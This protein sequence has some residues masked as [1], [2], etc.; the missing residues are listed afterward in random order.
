MLVTF[1][2][3]EDEPA[4][5]VKEAEVDVA[6]TMTDDGTEITLL[7]LESATN[8][9]PAGAAALRA[10]VQVLTPPVFVVLGLQFNDDTFTEGGG[11]EALT[12]TVADL[13]A[14]FKDPVIVLL[15]A[16]DTVPPVAV[17]VPLTP[18][19]ATDMLPGTV[20]AALLL[21]SAIVIGPEVAE[22]KL[23][24]QLEVPPEEIVVGLHVNPEIAGPT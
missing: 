24:V 7:L 19:T 1:E 8:A 23:T 17:N 6:G 22:D 9:P 13:D 2:L 11:A 15:C 12:V 3:P 5:A 14:P 18:P 10:T 4:V 21:E 20:T 16:V